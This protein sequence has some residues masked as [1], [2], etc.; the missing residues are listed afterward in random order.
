MKAKINKLLIK[1]GMICEPDAKYP[2]CQ[3]C[4]DFDKELDHVLSKMLPR[5][6][7]LCDGTGRIYYTYISGNHYIDGKGRPF[8]RC[9]D[10]NGTGEIKQQLKQ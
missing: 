1:Y 8:K 10:C 3:R 2:V 6:C 9:E 7:K 4:K 5:Q